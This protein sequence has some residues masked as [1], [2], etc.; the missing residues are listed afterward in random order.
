MK[1]LVGSENPVKIAAV[2]EAFSEYF[3]NPEIICFAADSGVPAQPV[4]ME[5][6]EGARNRA[7]ALKEINEREN[8]N[9][10]FFIGIEGGIIRIFDKWFAFGL[11]CIINKDGLAGYGSSS[12]FELPEQV[13]EKLLSGSELGRVM[14]EI[15]GAENT[16]QKGGAI[17]YFTNGI[18]DRKQLY[19]SGII[20]AMVPFHHK[21]LFFK[22]KNPKI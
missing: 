5:T 11:M 4:N 10:D 7:A 1:I 12:L 13:I 15:T 16:K 9:A 3:E 20:A 19:V 21:Q 14:D 18:M 17:G 22:E 6:F 2:K 8:L